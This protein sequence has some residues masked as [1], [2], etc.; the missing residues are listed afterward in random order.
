MD[1]KLRILEEARSPNTTA[2]E[3]LRR[4]QLDGATFYN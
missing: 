3:V 2:A 1:E 4:Y